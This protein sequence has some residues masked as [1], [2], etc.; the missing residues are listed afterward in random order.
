VSEPETSDPLV[1][2]SSHPVEQEPDL[3]SIRVLLIVGGV[4]VLLT[5]FFSAWAALT[6]DARTGRLL[7]PDHPGPD[8]A[9]LDRT[10]I[11]FQ[12]F[13]LEARGVDKRGLDRI[14]LE[15]HGWVDRDRGIAHIPIDTAMTLT[16]E[17]SSAE[18]TT[19]QGAD[20]P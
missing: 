16:L 2:P 12:L 17:R 19:R 9:V 1:E 5:V 11:E 10:D 15:S 6:V 8:A 14:R 7:S 20:A 13:D 4:L 3:Q 18:S